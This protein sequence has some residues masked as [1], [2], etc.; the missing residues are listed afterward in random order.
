MKVVDLV[1]SRRG[2][3][4]YGRLRRRRR[5]RRRIARTRVGN[6][7][8]GCRDDEQA[9]GDSHSGH[10]GRGVPLIRLEDSRTN[11]V[12]PDDPTAAFLQR[13]EQAHI[14]SGFVR[15]DIDVAVDGDGCRIQCAIAGEAPEQ[16][17][18][19]R[20]VSRL[21]RALGFEESARPVE[22]RRDVSIEAS[23]LCPRLGVENCVAVS[24]LA[25][26]I[27]PAVVEHGRRAA[28]AITGAVMPD[29]RAG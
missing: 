17:I 21:E 9:I 20:E 18:I 16:G 23:Q 11:L 14:G 19:V 13:V 1:R 15:A 25:S 27:E 10:W 8:R 2:A 3:G 6:N 12:G 28:A 26:H 5:R 22:C 7:P 24:A 4:W 29:H